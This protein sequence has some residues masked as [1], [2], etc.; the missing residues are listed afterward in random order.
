MAEAM[1]TYTPTGA[2]KNIYN[3]IRGVV[4]N[5]TTIQIASSPDEAVVV[6]SK[7][8]WNAMQEYIELLENGVINEVN[9]RMADAKAHPDTAFGDPLWFLNR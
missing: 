9:T 8:D 6:V 1:D 4:S 7:D 5:H 3:L 2:R